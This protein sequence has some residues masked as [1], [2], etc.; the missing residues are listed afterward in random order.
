M[1]AGDVIVQL[2]LIGG[3]AFNQAALSSATAVRRIG[4][5][6]TGSGQAI[7]RL[8]RYANNAAPAVAQIGRM[9]RTGALAMGA[10]GSAAVYAGIDFN[11]SMEQSK[12]AITNLTGSSQV[13]TNMLDQLYEIA[14]KT[15]FEFQDLTKSASMMLGFGYETKKVIP[16]MTTLGDAVA[17]VGGGAETIN[18]LTRAF[19]QMQAKGRLQTEELMQLAE[20]GIPAFKILQQELGLTGDQLRKQIEGGAISADKGIAALLAGM[21]KKYDGMAKAQSKTFRGQI[22]TLK[23]YF[24]QTMGAVTMPLFDF[25]R[26]QLLPKAIDIT[27]EIG[28]W[29]KQGGV[30]TAITAFQRGGKGME[31]EQGGGINSIMET[32]GQIGGQAF[33][34]LQDGFRITSKYVTDL[35]TALKPA[36]PFLANVLIPLFKGFG[37]GILTTVVFALKILLVAVRLLAPVLGWL[38]TKLAPL[39]TAFFYLGFVLGSIVG[40]GALKVLEILGKLGFVFKVLLIP[41]RLARVAMLAV[42]RVFGLLFKGFRLVGQLLMWVGNRFLAV[43][44]FVG[45]FVMRIWG[46][47]D[48]LNVFKTRMIGWA[49]GLVTGVYNQFKRFVEFGGRI[50]NWLVEGIKRNAGKVLDALMSIMPKW[51]RK[52]F[53]KVA[54]A[55]GKLKFW[56]HGG[57]QAHAGYA[58]VGEAGPELVHLPGGSQITPLSTPRVQQVAVGSMSGAGQNQT[59]ANFWLD[60]R[61][62]ATAVATDVEDRI[63][64]R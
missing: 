35:W 26:N 45:R 30:E 1:S 55:A 18:R 7:D 8:G 59:T 57:I 15:P 51:M 32:A 21:N 39:K 36:Q 56:Q 14:A 11:A 48:R 3:R 38:G 6:G 41:I 62:L 4:E 64:R 29:A 47:L 9:A 34:V 13:A 52:G 28:K 25:M 44:G 49:K 5:A 61:L 20:A 37:M 19:G 2:R 22:S 31:M 58:V 54:G 27:Q 46:L 53:G 23:D 50:I 24:R 17:G 63:A 33:K 40:P 42:A 12:V 10:L 60:R 43:G 16:F